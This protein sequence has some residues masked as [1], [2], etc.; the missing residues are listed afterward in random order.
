MDHLASPIVVCP[1]FPS[2]VLTKSTNASFD[3]NGAVKPVLL[4]SLKL[5]IVKEWLLRLPMSTSIS[6]SAIVRRDGLKLDGY[7]RDG[8][9]DTIEFRV[10]TYATPR[11]QD[12]TYINILPLAIDFT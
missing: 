10:F 2:G 12:Q 3:R 5:P 11:D 1:S 9:D 7:S 6:I 4:G 8:L